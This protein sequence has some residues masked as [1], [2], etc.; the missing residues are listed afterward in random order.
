MDKRIKQKDMTKEQYNAY[1]REVRQRNKGSKLVITHLDKDLI[2][3][4]AEYIASKEGK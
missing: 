2:N 4:I 1:I 3:L